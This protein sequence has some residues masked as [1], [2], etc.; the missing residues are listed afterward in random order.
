MCRSYKKTMSSNYEESLSAGN[1]DDDELFRF[2]WA[3]DQSSPLKR[4]LCMSVRR[5][6]EALPPSRAARPQM[7]CLLPVQGL[8]V[9]FLLSLSQ[10]SRPATDLTLHRHLPGAL[11]YLVLPPEP[12]GCLP[13]SDQSVFSL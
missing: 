4:W 12:R 8:T 10:W 11:G 9:L 5:Q 7:R 6:T 1:G 2:C 3:P 13:L